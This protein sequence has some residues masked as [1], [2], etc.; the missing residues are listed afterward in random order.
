MAFA[1]VAMSRDTPRHTKSLVL[2][3]LLVHL[4]NGSAYVKTG[5]ERL[6]TFRTERLEFFTP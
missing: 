6:D 1:H 2:L 4:R 3:E 5:A